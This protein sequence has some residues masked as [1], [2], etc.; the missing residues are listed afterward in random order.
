ME[1]TD[2]NKIKLLILYI[3]GNTDEH[4]T[5]QIEQ[6]LMDDNDFYED[7]LIQKTISEQFDAARVQ[8]L[9]KKIEHFKKN[10]NPIALPTA[11]RREIIWSRVAASVG[12]IL[13][14]VSI[15]W[16]I[17]NLYKT[18]KV[19]YAKVGV[20][21]TGNVMFGF[22]GEADSLILAV[23]KD[24]ANT[25]LFSNDTLKITFNKYEPDSIKYWELEHEAKTQYYTLST[26]SVDYDLTR[27]SS[28]KPKPL[29]PK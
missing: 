4:T 5:Q 6:R 26:G 29:I 1:I 22:A 28:S 7:Y 8:A 9:R 11:P 20:Y 10:D 12:G 25:Y 15:V 21:E 19:Q 16:W 27:D 23:T 17:A 18:D 13:A 14:L 24:K 2:D 3:E